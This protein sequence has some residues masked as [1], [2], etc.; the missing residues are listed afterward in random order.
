M[1]VNV[2]KG[3]NPSNVNFV[4]GEKSW[5]LMYSRNDEVSQAKFDHTKGGPLGKK[6]PRLSP[7]PLQRRALSNKGT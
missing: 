1:M 5:C 3:L 6:D 4:P 7:K 2:A